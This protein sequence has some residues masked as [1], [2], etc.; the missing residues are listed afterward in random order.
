MILPIMI[1]PNPRRQPVALPDSRHPAAG[2]ARSD[3][4]LDHQPAASVLQ[5]S[6]RFTSLYRMSTLSTEYRYLTE[7]PRSAYK[8]LFVK[9]TRIRA[10]VLYG[11]YACDEPMS[12]A[13][14]AA[15]YGLPVEAVE[16]AI[17]YCESNPPELQE[18]YQR[19]E[20]LLAA[21]GMDAPRYR[22]HCIPKRLSPQQR[23]HL[24]GS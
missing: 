5:P 17:R 21:T 16:E 4:G 6:S 20:A 1:L 18:D 9:G 24:N 14:I 23:Q 10:R 7:N 11:W 15:D 19:E 12:P 8:Q 22:D 2:R 13:E 3:F